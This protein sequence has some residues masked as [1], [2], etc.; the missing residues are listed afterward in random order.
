MTS[1]ETALEEIRGRL[2]RLERQNRRLEQLGIAALIVAAS[3]VLMGQASQKKTIEANEFI[4]RDNSGNV[5]ARLS[6]DEKFSTTQLVLFDK[7]GKQRMKADAGADAFGESFGATLTLADGH[8]RDRVFLGSD[9]VFGGTLSL[10]DQKGDPGTVLHADD[11]ELPHTTMKEAET[12]N[13]GLVAND[14]GVHAILAV[15]EDKAAQI[16]LEDKDNKHVLMLGPTAVSFLEFSGDIKAPP[17]PSDIKAVLTRG[18][19]D[20]ADELGFAA[21]VGVGDLIT[22]RTGET[23]KTSAAS[24]VLFDKDKNVIWKAP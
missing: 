22:P 17:K 19:L 5:R 20:L 12:S 16:A 13:L 15:G 7:E 10:L 24:L 2:I 9:D 3:L 21:R 11:A 14:K 23:H 6:V 4:L 18:S 1:Q 8:G